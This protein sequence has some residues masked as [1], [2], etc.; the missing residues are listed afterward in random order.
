MSVF[1]HHKS[2]CTYGD[3]GSDVDAVNGGSVVGDGDDGGHDGD[4]D[5]G[6]CMYV[7]AY[8]CMLCM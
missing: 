6:V 5:I 8:V 4:G 2:L 1:A 7:C 3:G